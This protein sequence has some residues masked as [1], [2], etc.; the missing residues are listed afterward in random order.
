MDIEAML[1]QHLGKKTEDAIRQKIEEFGGLLT[2]E[3]AIRLLCK[4]HG[5][6]IQNPISLA[7]AS[8]VILPFSFRAKVKRVFPVQHYPGGDYS[9]RVHVYDQTAEAIVVLWNEQAKVAFE[10]C[11]K[12]EVE[13][14]EA[15]FRN[16][17]IWIGKGGFLRLIQPA[18]R[19]QVE[20]LTAGVCTVEGRVGEIEPDY[21]Y[22]DKKTGKERKMS[23]FQLCGRQQCRRVVVWVEDFDYSS[24]GLSVGDWVVL[25]GVVFKSGE[26]HFNS[27][28]RL[29]KSA[30]QE[31]GRIG[32]VK[33]EGQSCIIEIENKKFQV[34]IPQALQLL[35]ITQVPQGVA[36]QALVQIKGETIVGKTFCYVAKNQNLVWM[37]EK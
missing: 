12:D 15:Y 7:D 28:S 24:Y 36:P 3:A 9:V 18:L 6:Y 26:I 19:M 11:Q 5:I 29:I 27:K 32:A 1:Q 25:D 37:A 33:V 8:K 23:S 35:G 21:F 20:E 4:Q 34:S 13:A 22:V 17:E 10:L 31:L 30:K 14:K 2:R 16:G